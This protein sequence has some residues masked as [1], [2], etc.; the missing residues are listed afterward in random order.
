ME[1]ENDAFK[2]SL[3]DLSNARLKNIEAKYSGKIKQS[4]LAAI[5]GSLSKTHGPLA[6]SYFA[7]PVVP[8][9][10]LSGNAD[11]IDYEVCRLIVGLHRSRTVF[12]SD[13]ERAALERRDDYRKEL[14][15]KVF[16]AIRLRPG[17]ASFLRK[18][19]LTS[20]D[21]FIF[22]E[23]PYDL[24]VLTNHALSLMSNKENSQIYVNIFNKGLAALSLLND[25]FLDSAYPI[26]RGIIELYVALLVLKNRPEAVDSFDSFGHLE[27]VFNCTEEIPD[28]LRP[29]FENRKHGHCNQTIFLHYG[30]IDAL[31]DYPDDKNPYSFEALFRYLRSLY[32]DP[33]QQN[34]F[35]LL[36][37]LYRHCHGYTHGNVGNSLYPLLHYFEI[38]LMLGLTLENTYRMLCAD[39]KAS[40]LIENTDVLTP[41]QKAL[42]ELVRQYGKRSTEAF[43]RYYKI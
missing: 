16:W 13:E 37:I 20:G 23:V 11:S 2:K 3:M 18:D 34:S 30:W 35:D 9:E 41:L 12:M 39:I 5:Y 1:M 8:E 43:K 7:F 36:D 14:T 26:C 19:P 15:D 31:P 6:L 33:E 32:P 25:N 10:D 4:F 24:L 22:Y 29:L 28:D 27:L 40:P 38:S 21:E 17:I 42:E